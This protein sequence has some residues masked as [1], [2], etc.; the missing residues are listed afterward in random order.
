[1]AGKDR[2][3]LGFRSGGRGGGVFVWM[4]QRWRFRFICGF[5]RFWCG[6][7]LNALGFQSSDATAQSSLGFGV[8]VQDRTGAAS[9]LTT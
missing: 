4:V 8:G 6:A 9:T 7:L 5:S 1:M 2:Q 3:A